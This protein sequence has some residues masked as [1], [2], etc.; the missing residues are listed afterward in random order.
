MVVGIE[1]QIRQVVADQLG[2]RTDELSE[3]VSLTDDL[4]ADSLDL[5][6]LTIAIEEHLNVAISENALARVRTYGDLV[7][8]ILRNIRRGR[9]AG[10]HKEPPQVRARVMSDGGREPLV[11][12]GQLTPYTVE[13]IGDAARRAG[14]GAALEVTA[15]AGASD[16]ELAWIAT[17]FGWLEERGI[18]VT[19]R[20]DAQTSTTGTPPSRSAP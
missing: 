6:E 7:D 16:V 20:R 5:V 11:Q 2:L 15:Q 9:A 18:A 19:V 12:T 1:P 4:A 17:Q 8:T 14:R 13:S 10:L 3:H